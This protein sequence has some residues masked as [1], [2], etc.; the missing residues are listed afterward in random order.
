[1]GCLRMGRRHP[2]FLGGEVPA[3]AKPSVASIAVAIAGLLFLLWTWHG[4]YWWV[5]ALTEGLLVPWDTTP[6]R[7]ALGT[8]QR[9][10]ND[11]FEDAPG[12]QMPAIAVVGGSALVAAIGT[13]RARRR[14]PLPAALAV[15][16]CFYA[17]VAVP[18]CVAVRARARPAAAADGLR[19]GLPSDVARPGG[20][21]RAPRVAAVGSSASSRGAGAC[22]AREAGRVEGGRHGHPAR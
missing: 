16:N 21:R 15:T 12:A 20:K 11:F 17:L 19:P 1:M 4:L 9:A 14:W 2:F 3:K 10:A 8:W 6:E 13:W 18:L 22:Q 7:P 5:A